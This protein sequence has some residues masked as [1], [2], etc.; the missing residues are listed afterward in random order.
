MPYYNPLI[1]RCYC[2]WIYLFCCCVFWHFCPHVCNRTTKGGGI[3][4][5]F[6]CLAPLVTLLPLHVALTQ[7][8]GRSPPTTE[9]LLSLFALLVVWAWLRRSYLRKITAWLCVARM[10]VHVGN[11]VARGIA[12]SHVG[13][14][15]L[16]SSCL[17][18]MAQLSGLHSSQIM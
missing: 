1:A 17:Q 4:L 13:G 10:C 16:A 5:V 2:I 6:S 3:A 12:L 9:L 11:P 15:A 8:R 7:S 18:L 14:K